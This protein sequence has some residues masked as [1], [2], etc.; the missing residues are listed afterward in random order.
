MLN[1]SFSKSKF[2]DVLNEP[3]IFVSY[4]TQP[5]ELPRKIAVERIKREFAS[6]DINEYFAFI[7]DKLENEGITP[8]LN[9]SLLSFLGEGTSAL[10]LENFYNSESDCHPLEH[11]TSLVENRGGDNGVLARGLVSNPGEE[12]EMRW[13]DC[14][15]T[16]FDSSSDLFAVKFPS[17]STITYL[18]RLLVCFI[19]EDPEKAVDRVYDAF[20]ERARVEMTLMFHLCADAMPVTHLKGLGQESVDIVLRKAL[21][22]PFLSSKNVDTVSLLN[23]VGLVHMRTLNELHLRN[24]LSSHSG[25]K[26]DPLMALIDISRVKKREPLAIPSVFHHLTL[27]SLEEGYDFVK[28]HRDFCFSSLLTR[29]DVLGILHTTQKENLNLLSNNLYLIPNKTYRVEEY[30]QNHGTSLNQTSSFIKDSWVF[31]ITNAVKYHL[32]NVKKGWFS[33]SE[34]SMEVH[35]FSKLHNFLCRVN[36]QMEDTLR[37]L[38]ISSISSFQKLVEIV[39][40]ANVV[41]H[42]PKEVDISFT[43]VED[44]RNHFNL[45]TVKLEKTENGENFQLSTPSEDM[46]QTM[47]SVFDSIF[48]SGMNGMI[49]VE[50]RVMLN[51]FWSYD[52]L[53][54]VVSLSEEWVQEIR[55]Y[56]EEILRRSVV[57]FV[58]YVSCYDQHLNILRL[59]IEEMIDTLSEEYSGEDAKLEDLKDLARKHME[60]SQNILETVPT[61]TNLG[62]VHV[63]CSEMR[64]FLCEKHQEYADKILDLLNEKT[65]DFSMVVSSKFS[66]I[67]LK[68]QEAPKDIE[69]LSEQKSFIEGVPNHLDELY[70]LVRRSGD[71]YALLDAVGYQSSGLDFQLRWEVFG[72]PRKL[73]EIME[74]MKVELMSLKNRMQLGMEEEQVEFSEK[75]KGLSVTVA[76]LRNLTDLSHTEQIAAKVRHIKG[77]LKRLD[78]L[79]KLFNSREALFGMEITEYTELNEISRSFDPFYLFWDSA[80]KWH[81]SQREWE[82]GEFMGLE[83]EDIEKSVNSLSKNLNKSCKFFERNDLPNNL[84]IGRQI[85]GAVDNFKPNV[86]LILALRNPGMRE[87]HWIALSEKLEVEIL[88]DEKLTLLKLLEIGVRDQIEVVNRISETAGKEFSLETALDKMEEE[89]ADVLLVTEE[90]RDTGTYILKEIDVYTALL[91]EHLTMAQ[92]MTFSS[93]KG[94]FEDRIDNWEENLQVVSEVIEEWVQVQKNWLYLEPI[95]SSPDI[96]KQ[97]PQEGKRFSTVDKLW[98]QTLSSASIEGT[99]AIRFCNNKRLLGKFQEGK[100]MLEM[101]QKGLSDYLETKRAGFS[102]FYFLSNDELLEILSESKDPLR[103]Q[104]HLKKAFEGIKSVNFEEDLTITA[105]KSSEGEIV[106]FISSVDPKGKNVENWMS[107]VCDVMC[108]SVRQ[109]MILALQDYLVSP[110]TQWMQTWPGQIVINGSQV[111]W[112]SEVE[113]ALNTKGNEGIGEYYTKC[114]DQLNDM[115]YLIR[116]KLSKM[117]RTTIGALAVI[118]V[119]ARDVVKKMAD[120]GVS[121]VGDFDWISQMRFYWEG[122]YDT[123][124]LSVI[125]VISKRQYGYEYLGN[126]FRLVITPLTDKCYLTMMGA[127]AMI[128]G[129]APAGPAGTGK[130]ETVKDLGKALAIQ[131]VVFNCSDGL[132]YLAMGKF[133]KGLASSGAWA[134]FDEFNRINLEVLSVIGQQIMTLQ[135]AVQRREERIVFEGTDINVNP[136]F[137]VFITMNPGYAGRSELPD[138]LEALF[139]PVAMMVPDYALIGEIMLFSFGY[140]NGRSCAKKMV[141]T[142]RLCSEQLSSQSHYDYGMR[143]VKTVI[144]A[145]GNLKRQNPEENE[146]ALLLRALQDV[147]I[148]KFLSPDLPLFAGILSD[149]FPGIK[150]PPFDYGPL[151]T[152]ITDSMKNLNLQPIPISLTKAIELYEMIVVRHGLM[153]VGPTGG[154]KSSNIKTLK[155]ALTMLKE[156]GIEGIRYE[157]VRTH[158]L[159]PKSIKMGQLYGEFDENTHEWRDGILCGII[160]A[161]IRDTT[162]DLKWI[163]FDGPV[164]ALWIENMNTVLDDNKKLCLVSG[165][166][167][168]LS[169]SMTMMFEPEDLA[170]ASPATVSRCGM[171]F[172]EPTS[173][174]YD[175]IYQ[176]WL[177]SLPPCFDDRFIIKLQSLFDSFI[178]GLLMMLRRNLEET[179]PTTT[180]GL[181]LALQSMLDC[182]F[183][184]YY[185]VEGADPFTEEAIDQALANIEPIFIFSLVWSITC[186]VNEKGRKV[187]DAIVRS[188]MD[189]FGCQI[190]FPSD[191]SIYD[192]CFNQEERCWVPWLE[193]SDPYKHDPGVSYAEMI[194]PTKDSICYTYLFDQ[195]VTNG[196]HVIM[197]GPTGTGKT[198]NISKHLQSGL[199]DKYIPIFLSFSAQ[200]SANQTQDLMDGKCEKRRKGVFGPQMG[201]KFVIFVDDINMPTKEEYGA[202]PPIELLRQWFDSS[203]WFDRKELS[204][205]NIV[206]VQF[207]SACGPPGGGRNHVTAR[208]Y[209]HFNIISYVSMD[210]QS[211]DVIFST[212]LHNFLL[213]FDESIQSLCNDIVAATI[214]IYSVIIEDLRPT[215]TKPHYMFNLRDISK[216]FQGVLMCHPR[217]VL[218]NIDFVRLWVHECKRIFSDRLVDETDRQWFHNL[219]VKCYKGKI[220]E[221]V[222]SWDSV[223][224]SGQDIIYTDFMI[225][226]ADPKIYEELRDISQLQPMVE[227]YLG[228]FNEDTKQPMPLVMFFDA[229]QHVTRI[230]RVLRQ[231]QGNALL[232][233]VG[234]SGRQSLCRLA[235]FIADIYLYQIEISKGYGIAEWRENIRDLLLKAGVENVP[236]VF[237]FSDTQVVN[238]MQMEDINGILNSGDVPNLYQAEHY[239]QIYTACKSE[240][241]KRRIVATKLNMFAQYLNRVR[242]NI[243]IVLA[244]SPSGSAFRNRVR[245]FPSLVNCCTLD[246]FNEWPEEALIS[247]AERLLEDETV[248]YG[249][250]KDVVVYFAKLIHQSVSTYSVRFKDELGRYNYVTPTSYLGLLNSYKKLLGQKRI[251]VGTL[252]QRLKVGLDKLISTAEKVEVLQVQLRDLEPQLIKTQAEVD[253]MIIQID[254]DKKV[255]AEFQKVV[256]AEESAASEK[257]ATTQAIADDAQRDLDEALPALDK[258]VECLK[259]LK[260]G[261]I[262]EVKALGRPPAGVILTMEACCIM[263]E[264]DPEKI[265]DPDTPGKKINDYFSSAKKHLLNDAKGLLNNMQT[266]DKDNIPPAVITKIAPF[267]ASEDFTPEKIAQASKACTAMCMWVRAMYMCHQVTLIV[268]PKKKQLAEAQESLDETLKILGEAQARLKENMDKINKLES[269]YNEANTKKEQLIHDVEECRARLDR[270]QKLIGG[271]GGERVRWTESCERLDKAFGNLIGDCLVAAGTISYAG[272]FTPE[273]RKMLVEMWQGELVKSGLPHTEGCDIQQTLA[274]PVLI[275]Q[276][277]ICKLPSDTHSVENGI[278]MSESKRYPLIIDPQNQANR[279]IKNMGKDQS[280]CENGLEVCKMTD[281]NFLRSL[282]NGVRFGKWILMENIGEELDAS[283]EPLLL[284]QIFKQGGTEMIKIGDST[285]PWNDSFSFF[286]TTKLSNPHYAPEVC[287]KVTLINF[288]ITFTGLEDQLLGVTIVEEE[289]EMEKRKH[290]LVVSNAKMKKE[291]K[292]I[293]DKILY[294]LSNSTG[295]ILDD[296]DL[297]NTLASSKKKSEEIQLKVEEAERTEEEIDVRR[298][299]YRPVAFRGAI[300]YFSIVDLAAVDPM[301]QYSLQW[302]TAL[303]IQAIR[304]AEKS[305]VLEERLATLKDY[306][307][308]YIYMNVC[309]S[310]FEMHKLLFSFLITIKILMGDNKIDMT[311]WGF[312]LSGVTQET[313]SV[314]NPSPDWIDGRMWN[315]ILCV[316]TLPGF[317]GFEASFIKHLK[318]WNE[319]YDHA[320]P[321]QLP[322]PG[323]DWETKLDPLQKLCILRCLRIDKCVEGIMDYIIEHLG[324]RFVEPPPFDLGACYSDSNLTTP[325]IFILSKGSDP[326]KK[327]YEFS[328][329]MKMDKRT[330]GISLGQGQGDKAV[331]LIDNAS[332]RGG[333]VYLQNCHLYISWLRELERICENLSPDTIH[334][335]FRLWLTSMPCPQFPVRFITIFT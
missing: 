152:S 175:P 319:L 155:G 301:Y 226:G 187:F 110:R 56:I 81:I 85:K 196:K 199:P 57:P 166:I 278:I 195:L 125:M 41:I 327:F 221:D 289:P 129:G 100:K 135:G 169:N 97:L 6:F 133:F 302:F 137:S 266:Y 325:L 168:T 7:V 108:A 198:V 178:S 12:G 256:E 228:E 55:G 18:P 84:E 247:V 204:F 234:G 75:L 280:F 130:T 314:D 300:L 34:S 78:E 11:W 131:T 237:L 150:R 311:E 329:S 202:Q 120:N 138:N 185:P 217:K 144:T 40:S 79:S 17:S 191:G 332:Q 287:V 122:D 315:E 308:Y 272:A 25:A 231:P 235:T 309:R 218:S 70:N 96:N 239:E 117:A 284:Q 212:I 189:A 14:E 54:H 63:S 91:D 257:A 297:I 22:S 295:E 72:W 47:L 220:D 286:L 118:D 170:V 299:G 21:S 59:N 156:Q 210:R 142:F 61:S 246:W 160:R 205:R 233:G 275:R 16:G 214:D 283:I 224:E 304:Q 174:G 193:T 259:N 86:P 68:V 331:A 236:V 44:F 190:L 35:A 229:L 9:S 172:Q 298:E 38:F 277:N 52:P 15:V 242:S 333:W 241:V 279:Y 158:H 149:L 328:R 90:Y 192:Y 197:T 255:A 88:P 200:T 260:K 103:V 268:E 248:D 203:G 179:L 65:R 162:E 324:Q 46:I 269:E 258:A 8:I 28:A 194:I 209:R 274:D 111:Y 67:Q 330:K 64:D 232:L 3:K 51:L 320:N 263:F 13:E 101:V 227:E 326:T 294:L 106:P 186:T 215:P 132:D 126:S 303:F 83:A 123:G 181:I 95:F 77:E 271:L 219:L 45:F 222:L 124:D 249:E 121:G 99:Q 267:Y 128:L 50:R 188:E 177:E 134:C 250:Y 253:A 140:M 87:R 225:P 207:V 183:A 127:L 159:N 154:G 2:D 208:F 26:R 164:D 316:S 148:P 157:K 89:W 102:R 305:E 244:F 296:H 153:V 32:Q 254:K 211:M 98:R 48:D 112:T 163:W 42:N 94:P 288:A 143:A 92:A 141:A 23:E 167:M 310:L 147:N 49:C 321:H 201:K 291:L 69:E 245:K 36:Y 30:Q 251:E 273:F 53:I 116:G 105:M 216:V 5:G 109:Q 335:D 293:E 180:N 334:K 20:L 206:D 252:H 184:K 80:D 230:A 240:C 281:K 265:P 104:P 76:N 317:K 1:K 73:N 176:S 39:C 19:S 139:R 107:E 282:E 161:C 165:E 37:S 223:I 264:V 262:D 151:L 323:N 82:E 60:A 243:H 115:V 113:S 171:I 276:W 270:A 33:L 322:L 307:T 145:A 292:E 62:L 10:P 238:Q 66:E 119:H 290:Q 4:Q 71:Q 58:E 43:N 306:F 213:S 114:C 261:D 136:S 74:E 93:F 313:L 318:Q 146:E 29:L 182:Y 27:P 285:I 24:S 312:L 31:T 173:L